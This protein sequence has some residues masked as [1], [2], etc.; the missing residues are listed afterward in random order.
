MILTSNLVLS[1]HAAGCAQCTHDERVVTMKLGCGRF[2]RTAMAG[3]L[4]LGGALTVV[5]IGG[6]VPASA[7]P[8]QSNTGGYSCNNAPKVDH[9][10]SYKLFSHE[11]ELTEV[12]VTAKDKMECTGVTAV[13]LSES[14]VATGPPN[15]SQYPVASNG[16]SDCTHVSVDGKAVCEG[17]DCAGNWSVV[18]TE[19][20]VLPD[21][22]P[23]NSYSSDC[24]LNGETLNC[25]DDFNFTVTATKG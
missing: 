23:W 19:T 6:A 11:H 24:T 18:E 22:Y 16:C 2:F 20:W 14:F 1:I 21:G 9:K 5:V 13:Q 12:K 7:A 25:T 4:L 10:A 8:L 15:Q 3:S 17:L